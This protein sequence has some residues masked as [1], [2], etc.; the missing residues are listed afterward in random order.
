MF[1]N[2]Q[3]VFGAI[4]LGIADRALDLAVESARKRTSI[5]LSRSMA[6]HPEIQHRVAQMVLAIEGAGPQVERA[7]ADWDALVDHGPNWGTKLIAAKEN[8]VEAAKKVVDLAMTVSG[9]GGMYKRSELERLYRDVRAGGFH[10]ANSMLVHELVGKT[11]LGIDP[12][13]QPRWG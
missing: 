10:P 8:A 6:Y 4:Y 3:P 12:A 9:G 13:E 5:A 7:A 11:A 1:A 2:T